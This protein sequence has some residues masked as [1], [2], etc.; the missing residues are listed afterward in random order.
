M[1]VYQRVYTGKVIKHGKLEHGHRTVR[2]VYELSRLRTA[3]W[4]AVI[5]KGNTAVP[6]QNGAP[7]D[8]FPFPLLV[9]YSQYGTSNEQIQA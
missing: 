5:I 6:A 4:L 2:K 9:E 1:L 7:C 3:S 8:F